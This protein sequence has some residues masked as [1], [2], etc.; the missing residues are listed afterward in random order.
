MKQSLRHLNTFGIQA[1]A[2][3][4]VEIQSKEQLLQWRKAQPGEDFFVLGEGS[5]VLFLGDPPM[6]ILHNRMKGIELLLEQSDR[7][8]IR[9]A[10]GE[11]WHNLVSW[12]VERNYNGIENLALIPGSA[13]AAPV[14]NIGAYGVELADVLH[15]VEYFDDRDEKIKVLPARDCELAY[16]SSIFKGALKGRS[17]ITA[18]VIDLRKFR[19]E[20]PSRYEALERYLEEKGI[21][22]PGIKDIFN[23]VIDIRQSKLPDPAILG[24]A[25][26]FFKNPVVDKLHFMELREK[27]PE[28][29][30]YP[31]G[32]E[33]T[34][35]AAGW[36]ID[37]AGW[38]GKRLG[39]VGCYEKQAL[40]LVNY[41][42]ATGRDVQAFAQQ[43]KESVFQHFGVPLE[44][45][46]NLVG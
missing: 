35:L 1:D 23:A 39:N 43:V 44:E 36:L 7:V 34:K 2:D 25:G 28:I 42:G 40:V 4:F 10:S 41:G 27:Y 11:N 16:R 17:F 12:A 31:A 29:P 45:E 38:R 37:R 20:S 26:S 13:G 24:N 19:G 22:R 15:S 21:T 46:V 9:V 3:R 18:I 6:T 8:R 32:E 5:N 14:Q 33:R 30:G